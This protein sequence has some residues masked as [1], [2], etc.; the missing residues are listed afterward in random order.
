MKYS[1]DVVRPDNQFVILLSEL[2][3]KHPSVDPKAVG[4]KVDWQNEPLLEVK[5]YC[6]GL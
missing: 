1:L 2:F 5:I 6:P 3:E 4:R